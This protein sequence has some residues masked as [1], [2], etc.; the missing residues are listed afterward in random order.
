MQFFYWYGCFRFLVVMVMIISYF[1]DAYNVCHNISKL[2]DVSVLN[3]R[4]KPSGSF[5]GCSSTVSRLQSHN[6]ETIYLLPP[7]TQ[8]SLY[9][10]DRPRKEERLSQPL[11]HPVVLNPGRLDFESRFL[12]I[13]P[14][15]H[16]RLITSNS[17]SLTHHK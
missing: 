13:R 14:L 9:S 4:K 11:S 7:S 5:N 3:L 6:E 10:F 12:T 8:V 1:W 15:H 2:Y 16:F 17:K